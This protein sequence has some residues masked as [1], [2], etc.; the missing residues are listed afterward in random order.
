MLRLTIHRSSVVSAFLVAVLLGFTFVIPAFSQSNATIEGVVTDPSDA[1]VAAAT[2][3]LR[4]LPSDN[5]PVQAASSG[6]GR[7]QLAAAAG[8]YRLTITH[9]GLRRYE[10][11]LNLATGENRELHVQLALEPLSSSV[12][13]S[14][15]AQPIDANAASESVSI[16]T[17][18]NIDNRQITQIAPLLQS[19]PGIS[20]GQ[21]GPIGGITALFLDGGNSNYTKVLIDGVPLN[22]PGGAVNTLSQL[23]LDGVDKIEVTRGA[24]SA[25]VGSDAMSGVVAVFTNRGSTR[26]PLLLAESDGGSFGTGRGTAQLSG[27]VGPLDYSVGA[28]YY[29]THGQG[30]NDFF[31]DRTVSGN[32]GLRLAERDSL[33]LTIR[34][35]SSD[36]G[37]PGQTLFTPPSLNQHYDFHDISA[38]VSWDFSTGPHWQHRLFGFESD[39]HELF[40]NPLSAFFLSPDPFGEC[41]FPRSPQ[42]VPSAYCD[43]PFI[44]RN[45]FN[46]GG[47]QGQSTY[48]ARHFSATLG[49]EYEVENAYLQALNGGHARRNNQAGFIELRWQATGR[50]AFNAGFRVEDNAS[51]G[52]RGVPRTGAAYTLRYGH[53]FW[54]A[55]RLRFTYGQ[56]IK[57][58]RLD[59]SFGTDPCNPGNLGLLPEQSRTTYAGI[60]QHLDQDKI[61]VSGDFFY[62]QF[63]NITSFTFCFTGSPCPVTPP[64]GCPFGFGTYFN[65]DLARARGGH[66]AAEWQL[67]KRISL[68]ANY[69]YD[70]SRVLVSPNAFDPAQVPGNRLLRRPV[71]SGSLV[72]NAGIARFQGNIAGIF[73]GRRTDSDFLFPPLG[74]TSDPGYMRVDVAASYRLSAQ[75]SVIGH[76]TNLF[77]KPY[78]DVL[79]F[80]AL[81]RAAYI[82]MRFRLGGE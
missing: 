29:Q 37:E 81:G 48:T 41:K 42:A 79:G 64:P 62:N 21:T 60:E 23:T 38:G 31:V 20:L 16:L 58:P 77:N 30:P 80:P 17:R 10:Q 18:E 71:N 66:L 65:T 28:G 15:A 1:V 75:A 34:S 22:E 67:A 82:G 55:T 4:Q 72:L 6:E 49:Y 7:F 52:T 26:R 13:V 40:D 12:I 69:S 68:D 33:R 25:L 2:I 57:E 43:F 53:D 19:V 9:P 76:V 47:F 61:R 39:I 59:Q 50:L 54:G 24:E 5:H 8:R 56:G 44:T 32:F 3:E 36:A 51:F 74:L 73:V 78:Q 27:L 70:D 11:Q 14:T 46:R 45:Q 63:R 35:N